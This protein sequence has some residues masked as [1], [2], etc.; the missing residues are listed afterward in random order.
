MSPN[1]AIRQEGRFT[2]G[3]LVVDDG[4]RW[5]NVLVPH[6]GHRDGRVDPCCR[7]VP[8]A[9]AS[10]VLMSMPSFV[11]EDGA[12]TGFHDPLNTGVWFESL[13]PGSKHPGN[14]IQVIT[15]DT[16]W[17]GWKEGRDDF[18]WLSHPRPFARLPF[19]WFR[20]VRFEAA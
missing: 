17:S 13:W 20:V 4:G 11:V 7:S 16:S 1:R 3:V 12:L 5:E 18:L 8:K 15:W 6:P 10:A 2:F 19:K 9:R 14:I